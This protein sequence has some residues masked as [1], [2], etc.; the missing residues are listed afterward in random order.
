MFQP[1]RIQ[2]RPSSL[3]TYGQFIHLDSLLARAALL[4][5]F[6]SEFYSLPM[7]SRG[8]PAEEL[9]HPNLPL[10]RR[11]R[12]GQWYWAC[13]WADVEKIALAHTGD[14]WVKGFAAND[15]G[16]YVGKR[17]VQLS[18]G[19]DKLYN[20]PIHLTTVSELSWYAMGN[21]D[22]IRRLLNENYQAIGKKNAYG[23]GQLEFYDDG[24]RW[25]VEAWH[26][27]WSERDGEGK[28]TRGIPLEDTFSA[29]SKTAIY[30]VRPPYHV[31]AN[32]IRLEMP[33]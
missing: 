18:K 30:G 5:K 26:S 9:I 15:A 21:P 4:E 10:E 6:G 31:A 29:D 1:V 12:A 11:E 3:F 27:D 8:T 28:L 2:C 23:N 16:R 17:T 19:P 24:N 13:S 25:K 32:Q 7:I 33:A 20:M 14:G 22:E